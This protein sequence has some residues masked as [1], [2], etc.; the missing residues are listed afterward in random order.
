MVAQEEL[1]HENVCTVALHEVVLRHPIVFDVFNLCYMHGSGKLR[2]LS[3]AM[4]RSPG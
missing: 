4:L 3:V 2:Q 1:A